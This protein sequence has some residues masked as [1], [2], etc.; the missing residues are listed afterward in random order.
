M[1]KVFENIIIIIW[2]KKEKAMGGGF[3]FRV[4]D[5]VASSTSTYQMGATRIDTLTAPMTHFRFF[6]SFFLPTFGSI[7]SFPSSPN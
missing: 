1:R 2:Q 6:F 5:F 4:D 3:Y 7:L